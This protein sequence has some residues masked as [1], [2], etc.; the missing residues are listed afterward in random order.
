[1]ILEAQIHS[2]MSMMILFEDFTPDLQMK[3]QIN[4]EDDDPPWL[5]DSSCDDGKTSED[6]MFYKQKN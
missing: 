6:L 4:F 3:V 1:M 5:Y 2:K